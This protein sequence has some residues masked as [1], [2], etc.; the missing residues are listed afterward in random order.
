MYKITFVSPAPWMYNHG[1]DHLINGK[2]TILPFSWCSLE[3]RKTLSVSSW[4]CQRSLSYKVKRDKAW[5]SDQ[6]V[7][8]PTRQLEAQT[9]S[10]FLKR[11]GRTRR[12]HPEHVFLWIKEC[13]LVL[14][15]AVCQPLRTLPALRAAAEGA[16]KRRPRFDH[17]KWWVVMSYLRNRASAGVQRLRSPPYIQY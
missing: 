15:A 1:I 14:S 16:T 5:R 12:L 7:T 17:M 10:I 3:R 6:S 4:S 2:S 8:R 11:R 13:A 9:F